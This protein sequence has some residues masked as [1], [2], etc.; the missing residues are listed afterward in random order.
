MAKRKTSGTGTSKL[1][2]LDQA[3]TAW[4]QIAAAG[5]P[6][7]W[8]LQFVRDD[9]ATWL[10]GDRDAHGFRLLA[11]G[12]FDGRP[13]PE[14]LVAPG[15]GTVL[16]PLTAVEVVALHAELRAMLTALVTA[17]AANSHLP[18]TGPRP[19][20][21]EVPTEGLREVLVRATPPGVKPAIFAVSR[22][23]PLRTMVFQVVKGLVLEAGHQLLACPHCNL[24]FL[25]TGKRKF[26]SPVCRQR[27]HDKRR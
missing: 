26:C 23:G 8:L 6:L 16:E 24:P 11:L 1:L 17:P 13:I 21:V 15:E 7:E 9:A 3:R 19:R 27:W 4:S 20:L 5:G 10:P 25:A 12:F 14:W 18:T 22:G 2:I